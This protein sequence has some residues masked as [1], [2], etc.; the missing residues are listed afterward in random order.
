MNAAT[1]PVRLSGWVALIVGLALNAVLGWALDIDVK[2]IVAMSA[3]LALTSIGG[4]E[5]ARN[6]VTPVGTDTT[7]A[8]HRLHDDGHADLSTVIGGLIAAILVVI[9]ARLL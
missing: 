1:E 4:L 7:S 3:T 6:R 9:L 5:W 2:A 8:N